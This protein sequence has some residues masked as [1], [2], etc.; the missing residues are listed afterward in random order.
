MI[1]GP[2]NTVASY[3]VTICTYRGDVQR[4][5]VR[6]PEARAIFL[7]RVSLLLSQIKDQAISGSHCRNTHY[8]SPVSFENQWTFFVA[9][10]HYSL[11]NVRTT[12]Q[13]AV[14][15]PMIHVVATKKTN[16]DHA[17]ARI[18]KVKPTDDARVQIETNGYTFVGGWRVSRRS[19]WHLALFGVISRP[20][21]LRLLPSENEQEASSLLPGR[22]PLEK[23]IF[24]I[25][26]SMYFSVEAMRVWSL[27]LIVWENFD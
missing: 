5:A 24:W 26:G 14:K 10:L 3:V 13:G 9:S 1:V 25:G 22:N 19:R 27:K 6:K 8:A 20:Y 18:L 11:K 12:L 16:A 2:D 23:T 15:E 4:F 17:I 7:L 21:D